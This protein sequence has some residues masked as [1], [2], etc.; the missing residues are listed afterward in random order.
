[1]LEFDVA[2]VL[3]LH[4]EVMI[5]KMVQEALLDTT[6]VE[7]GILRKTEMNTTITCVVHESKEGT[8]EALDHSLAQIGL[9]SETE[10]KDGSLLRI[11]LKQTPEIL[12]QIDDAG[13]FL[14]KNEIGWQL[15]SLS[16]LGVTL[17]IEHIAAGEGLI[18]IPFE[19]IISI[20]TLDQAYP[21]DIRNYTDARS[22]KLGKTS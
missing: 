7:H 15:Q 6:E 4:I 3:V 21:E 1:L 13:Y 12:T 11:Q 18:F 14:E 9:K 17:Y 10:L 2:S 16:E 22:G 8:L 19:N 20:C 5:R